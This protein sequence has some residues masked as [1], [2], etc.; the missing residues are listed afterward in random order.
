MNPEPE[1]LWPACTNTTPARTRLTSSEMSVGREDAELSSDFEVGGDGGGAVVVV[2]V[3][4][5]ASSSIT[6]VK[7]RTANTRPTE[8]APPRNE[9]KERIARS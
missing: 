9:T 5:A 3:V 1:P 2:V 8:T 6:P 7:A 4:G